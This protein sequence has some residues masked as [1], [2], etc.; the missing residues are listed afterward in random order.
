M[1]TLSKADSSKARHLVRVDSANKESVRFLPRRCMV[2][3]AALIQTALI[4]P[5]LMVID[6]LPVNFPLGFLGWALAALG[7]YRLLT[8]YGEV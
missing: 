7:G 8:Q 2:I 3:A 5:L 4:I 1:A 6:W